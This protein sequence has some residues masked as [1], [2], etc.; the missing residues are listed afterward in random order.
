MRLHALL[1]KLFAR[2]LT[3]TFVFEYTT[4]RR[5]AGALMPAQPVDATVGGRGLQ[6]RNALARE[7][8]ARRQ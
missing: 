3:P 5:Q 1:S 2:E 8:R 4:I 6:R 7:A